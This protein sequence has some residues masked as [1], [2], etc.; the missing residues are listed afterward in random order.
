MRALPAPAPA[1]RPGRRG[2]LQGRFL[3]DETGLLRPQF[4][5]DA[6]EFRRLLDEP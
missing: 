5:L 1:Q 2:R 3:G 6:R 4:L